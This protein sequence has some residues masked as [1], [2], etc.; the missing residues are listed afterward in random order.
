MPGASRRII[1]AALIHILLIF[2][3]TNSNANPAMIKIGGRIKR[4][5]RMPSKSGGLRK[6]AYAKGIKNQAKINETCI[7][8]SKSFFN[9][10]YAAKNPIANR[11]HTGS[12]SVKNK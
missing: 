7:S 3:K 4:K 11:G 6:M 12:V 2:S 5:W 1:S 10:K 9:L 8:F